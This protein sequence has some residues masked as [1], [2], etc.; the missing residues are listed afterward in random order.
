MP[1]GSDVLE[2]L[3]ILSGY[4][5]PGGLSMVPEHDEIWIGHEIGPRKMSGADVESMV[6]LGFTWDKDIPAWHGNVSA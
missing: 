4:E 2:A 3:K 6:K 5:K 1:N